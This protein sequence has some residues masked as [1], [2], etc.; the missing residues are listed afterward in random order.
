MGGV[1]E[2]AG[3]GYVMPLSMAPPGSI[4]RV[5]R[6]YAGRGLA[7]RL[8]ELGLTNGAEVRVLKNDVGPLL[9]HVRGVTIALG[10]GVA[11]KIFVERIA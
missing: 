10:R 5:V 8:M 4:V 11:S 7:Q 1:A 3:R 9:L 2:I 6:V